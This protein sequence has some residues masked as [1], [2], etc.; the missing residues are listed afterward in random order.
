MISMLESVMEEKQNL[1]NYKNTYDY[2]YLLMDYQDFYNSTLA[3][4]DEIAK[5]RI[6]K[7]NNEK[8]LF[9]VW[10]KEIKENKPQTT[11]SLFLFFRRRPFQNLECPADSISSCLT[12]VDLAI[13]PLWMP[14][15][16][17]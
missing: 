9:K 16:S 13:Q 3:S 12:V 4:F 7:L 1:M 6:E 10:V 8:M 5:E 14:A 15:I 11:G 17:F 2:E